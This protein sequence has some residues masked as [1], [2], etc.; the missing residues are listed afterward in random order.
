MEEKFL[1]QYFKVFSANNTIMAC[2]RNE[3]IQL[4]HLANKLEPEVSHGSINTGI[5]E[6][7]RIKNLKIKL[8][9]E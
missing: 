2:G 9:G 3:C 8:F 7:E 4:I 5:M 6:V 1:K